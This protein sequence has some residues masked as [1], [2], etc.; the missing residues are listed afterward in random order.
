MAVS[1]NAKTSGG[2]SSRA[3]HRTHTYQPQQFKQPYSHWPSCD[4]HKAAD[5]SCHP[6]RSF[7]T[8]SSAFLFILLVPNHPLPG[9]LAHFTSPW[10]NI[11]GKPAPN[12]TPS[13]SAD[14]SDCSSRISLISKRDIRSVKFTRPEI[15]GSSNT[16]SAT[17]ALCTKLVRKTRPSLWNK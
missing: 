9:R 3:L 11:S 17:L 5:A 15:Y 4:I 14:T 8:T 2:S 7:N 6:F 12:V 16:T 1:V 10:L 13:A